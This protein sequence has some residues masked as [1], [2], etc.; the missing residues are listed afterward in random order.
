MQHR[1]DTEEAHRRAAIAVDEMW[2]AEKMVRVLCP[3]QVWEAANSDSRG[4]TAF[5]RVQGR[6]PACGRN[7]LFL[8]DGGYV[9]CSRTLCSEPDAASTLLEVPRRPRP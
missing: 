2:L 8:G 7:S 5:Q 6:C 3:A 9:T 4:G 1:K